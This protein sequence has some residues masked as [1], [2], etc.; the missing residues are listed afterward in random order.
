MGQVFTLDQSIINTMEF[1]I[2]D[3]ILYLGK[4]CKVVYAPIMVPCVNCV[5]DQIGNKS[6]NIYLHGGPIAFPMGSICPLCDGAGQTFAEEVSEIIR[7]IVHWNPKKYMNVKLDNMR[8]ADGLISIKGHISDMPK[9]SQM[10]YFIPHIELA[11]YA[12][13]RFRLTSEPISQGNI[14]QGK[15]FTALLE[16]VAG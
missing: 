15:F 9:I 14:V 10:S 13:Y 7:V 2:N 4:N 8:I 12:N 6:K 1:A 11:G 5:F 16:R 3:L